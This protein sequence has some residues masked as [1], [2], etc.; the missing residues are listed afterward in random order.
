MTFPY[1]YAPIFVA[2]AYLWGAIPTA[3]LIARLASGID[4]REY[5]SGNVGASNAVIHIGAVKGVAIEIG[6]AH[7]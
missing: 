4:I 6:R 5:G 2:A 1:A 7:V 3:Y